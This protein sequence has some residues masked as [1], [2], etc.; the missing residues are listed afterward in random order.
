MIDEQLEKL[1]NMCREVEINLASGNYY[2][3]INMDKASEVLYPQ[4]KQALSQNKA[5]QFYFFLG[6]YIGELV[7][8]RILFDKGVL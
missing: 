3:L 7:V 1:K 8:L 2:L 6:K 5:N 4:L